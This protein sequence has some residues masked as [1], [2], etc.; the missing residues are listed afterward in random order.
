MKILII[1]HYAGS[2]KLGMEFRPYYLAKEWVKLG[3]Q[4]IIIGASFS[5]LRNIQPL[6]SKDLQSTEEN[7]VVYVWLRTPSYSSSWKRILNMLIFVLKLLHYKKKIAETFGPDVVIASSTYPL[8]I[9]PAKFIA[10]SSKAK[11]CF[12]VHDLWPM[13]P[14]VIGGY[15]KYH[16]F[17][18]MMQGAENFAYKNSDAVVS[19]LGNAKE[20]MNNHGLVSD[21][22][23]YIPNG[24]DR[25]EYEN[26]REE[27]PSEHL[28]L[29]SSLRNDDNLLIGYAGGHGPSNTLHTLIDAARLCKHIDRIK[30]ILVGSGPVKSELQ[31]IS[32][33]LPNVFFLDSLPK[34]SIPNLLLLFDILYIGGVKSILHKYGISPNKLIDYMLAAKPI[35]LSADV[36]N[37]IVERINCGITVPAEDHL[38]VFDAIQ[39]FMAMSESERID[40]GERGRKYAKSELDY[41]NLAEKFIKDIF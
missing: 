11:L 8:D 12:E 37:E 35:L 27:P 3:H 21:K 6:V 25:D 13:S 22:F 28:K 18:L 5:H 24:F 41:H 1:N 32:K 29:L 31:E 10:K 2:P 17:I 14:M 26:M 38:A 39:K 19:L 34:K 7:G 23:V 33:D 36:E 30:F 9:Y 20:H 15:S 16:P 4:A 40:M